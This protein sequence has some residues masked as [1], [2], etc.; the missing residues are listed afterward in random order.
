MFILSMNKFDMMWDQC[1]YFKNDHNFAELWFIIIFIVYKK[2]DYFD[3]FQALMKLYSFI[4][5]CKKELIKFKVFYEWFL[6]IF[7]DFEIILLFIYFILLY[8][9]YWFIRNKIINLK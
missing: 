1:S 5:Y 2:N 4:D 8:N 3:I 9:K 7:N 6:K